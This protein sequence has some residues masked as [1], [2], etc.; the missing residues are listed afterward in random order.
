[1]K[2][3]RNLWPYGIILAFIL[4][5]GGMAAVIVIAATHREHLVTADYYE[6]ELK[7]QGQIDAARRAAKTGASVAHDAGTGQL[8]VRLDAAQ[9]SQKIAGTVELYRPSAP[10][11]DREFLLELQADGTQTINLSKL[12]IGPWLVRV[13]WSAGGQEYFLEQK[14]RI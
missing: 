14:I 2:T 9:L 13:K 12:A 5:F 3:D 1:M 8:I 4:F 7:F 10:E 11:L 6:Q